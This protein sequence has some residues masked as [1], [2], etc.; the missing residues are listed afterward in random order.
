MTAAF[1]HPLSLVETEQLGARSNVYAF[2]HI[3]AGAFVGDDCNIGDHCFIETGARIGH[4]CTIKNG[5]SIWDGIVL[6]DGV[7]VGPGA[8]FANDRWP[9]SRR[10]ADAA[11]RYED[12]SWRSTTQVMRGVSIGA[13]AIVLPGVT[14]RPYAMVGAGAVVTTDV[15]SRSCVVGSPARCIGAVCRCGLPTDNGRCEECMS[16]SPGWDEEVRSAW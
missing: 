12:D 16:E 11:H 3:Q 5:V 6:G 15:P 10:L 8:V 1:V 2:A 14:I 9:R 7:F 4:G 13:G